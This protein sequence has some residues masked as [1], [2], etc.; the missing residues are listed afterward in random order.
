[1]QN[2]N[3]GVGKALIVVAALL[4]IWFSGG[5]EFLFGMT[6]NNEYVPEVRPTSEYE[7]APADPTQNAPQAD[8]F[9]YVK[10]Q[11]PTEMREEIHLSDLF[12]QNEWQMNQYFDLSV[13]KEANTEIVV[14]TAQR[15]RAS[16]QYAALVWPETWFTRLIGTD[17][18]VLKGTEISTMVAGDVFLVIGTTPGHVLAGIDSIQVNGNTVTIHSSV[19]VQA[20]YLGFNI[21]QENNN[22]QI[23][24]SSLKTPDPRLDSWLVFSDQIPSESDLNNMGASVVAKEATWLLLHRDGS[25][26]WQKFKNSVENPGQGNAYEL[27]APYVES[28]FCQK[29]MSEQDEYTAELKEKGISFDP[30]DCND[31]SF[32]II[33][34]AKLPQ[35]SG[36]NEGFEF[37][38]M[39]RTGFYLQ[40]PDPNYVV[41]D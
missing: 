23:E 7:P 5:R 19:E 40:I 26:I 20:L 22:P 38:K 17:G 18:Q 27:L 36:G 32:D 39:A 16:E 30:I 12:D 8:F 33:I 25:D 11:V 13:Y 29:F 4:V 31:V 28:A 34:E 35:D 2:N 1:M 9:N 6:Q 37:I 41:G 24:A 3:S 21:S 10:T 15:A 14:V